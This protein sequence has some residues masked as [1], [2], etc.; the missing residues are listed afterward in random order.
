MKKIRLVILLGMIGLPGTAHCEADVPY[1]YIPPNGVIPDS[2]TAIRMAE[3]ILE[4]IYGT[5]QIKKEQPLSAIL[6]DNVWTITGTLPK[7]ELGGTAIV[8]I[9]KSDGQVKRI[10]HG[11]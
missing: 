2:K 6:K 3:A 11:Q 9:S 1:N 8:E 7:G 4:P 10:S 5:D